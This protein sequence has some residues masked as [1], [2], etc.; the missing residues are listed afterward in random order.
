M[1]TDVVVAVDM[2]VLLVLVLDELHHRRCHKQ[3]AQV[4]GIVFS[5]VVRRKLLLRGIVL[6]SKKE[7]KKT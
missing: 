1:C 4:T 7:R 5:V 3:V 6:G 2:P